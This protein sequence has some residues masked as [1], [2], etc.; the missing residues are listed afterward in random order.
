MQY[1]VGRQDELPLRLVK[2]AG[3]YRYKVFIERLGWSLR[4]FG[5]FE[6]DE[7]DGPNAIYVL[8]QNKNGQVN[9]VARLLPTTIPYLLEKVFPSLWGGSKLPHSN[10]VWEL[11]RFSAMDFDADA[12]VAR[13]ASVRH[14]A[15]FFRKV[16]Q[17]ARTCGARQLITVSPVGVERLLRAN[18]YH[19]LRGGVME[20]FNGESLVSLIIDLFNTESKL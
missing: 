19:L 10:E 5:D 15:S 18:K 7:F 2:D 8:S 16:L 6:S 9:G 13:Q 20:I 4:S 17:V 12:P 14:T 11:S 1:V 3:Y